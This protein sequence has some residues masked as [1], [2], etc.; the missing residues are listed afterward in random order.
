MAD[1]LRLA[2]RAEGPS[3]GSVTKH[4]RRRWITGPA[5]ETVIGL[6]AIR[7]G[8]QIKIG[9]CHNPCDIPEGGE[10]ST[11]DTD[12]EYYGKVLTID[13]VDD[14]K[15]FPVEFY[16]DKNPDNGYCA[17]YCGIVAWRRP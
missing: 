6:K 10:H 11:A 13:L 15:D 14:H 9:P 2:A 3:G 4:S 7:V 5:L 1:V 17:C 12:A 8:D 16:V